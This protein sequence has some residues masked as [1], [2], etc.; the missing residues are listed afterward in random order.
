[1]Y[2]VNYV[3]RRLINEKILPRDRI[4]MVKR[5][6][7]IQVRLPNGRTYISRYNRLMFGAILLNVE[8]NRPFKQRPAPKSKGRHHQAVQQQGWGLASILKIAKEIAKNPLI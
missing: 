4:I 6:R 5:E 1:M 2:H 8:L 3:G 7:P